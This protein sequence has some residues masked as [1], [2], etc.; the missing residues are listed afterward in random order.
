MKYFG[1][2]TAGVAVGIVVGGIGLVK[3]ATKSDAVK[4]AINYEIKQRMK[5]IILEYV[6]ESLNDDSTR[7]HPRYESCCEP[8]YE[9]CCEP[10]FKGPSARR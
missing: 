5:K 3:I 10:S 1:A 6:S 4:D 2:F 8:R 7:K 9:S